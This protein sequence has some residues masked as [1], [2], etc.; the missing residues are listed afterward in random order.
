[1]LNLTPHAIVVLNTLTGEKD[2]FPPSGELA[3]VDVKDFHSKVTDL[4]YVIIEVS[5]GCVYGVP[6]AG[7]EK[8]LVSAMVL[9]RLGPE[10]H[11]W[12]FSPDSGKSAVRNDKGYIEY[13]RCLK[14]VSK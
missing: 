1:M 9:D 6:E 3:R 14:T 11:G 5:Y 8:F 2:T 13:V 12:A 4:P 10:Y 7:T